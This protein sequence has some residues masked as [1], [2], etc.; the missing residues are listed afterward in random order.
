[1]PAETDNPNALAQPP[2]PPGGTDVYPGPQGPAGPSVIQEIN[3]TPGETI[4]ETTT[5]VLDLLKNP[6]V[7][8][9]LLLIVGGILY[10]AS[11]KE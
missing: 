11:K 10:Q 6:W 9:A 2:V 8:L 1:M 3:V 7:V 5:Q 4:K